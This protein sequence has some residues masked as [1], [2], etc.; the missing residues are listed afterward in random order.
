[1]SN[2]AETPEDFAASNEA[3]IAAMNAQHAQ[4][5]K[6]NRNYIG[7]EKRYKVWIDKNDPN[8]TKFGIPP[9]KYISVYGISS[10]YLQ[11]SRARTDGEEIY[12]CAQ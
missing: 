2:M 12:L 10:Y 9:S 5:E 3:T 8:R 7:E 4:E 1:M 11:V 6:G